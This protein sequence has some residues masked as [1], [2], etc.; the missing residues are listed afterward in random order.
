MGEKIVTLISVAL[1]SFLLLITVALVS[2]SYQTRVTMST[3]DDFVN[4]IMFNGYFSKESYYN[5]LAKIP[6]KNIKIN[7]S[8]YV[9]EEEGEWD[10][11]REAL[12]IL[13]TDGIL[14][15][16]DERYLDRNMNY[17]ENNYMQVGD[18]FKVDVIQLGTNSFETLM[19]A[20][21]G[22]GNAPFKMIVSRHTVIANTKYEYS[23]NE[24]HYDDD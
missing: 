23:R 4:E 13:F 7:M 6:M 5:M 18:V 16:H 15:G 22:Q 2:S 10:E 8:R 24:T 19:G 9:R 1:A 11:D 14:Q 3:V 20:L 21:A 12:N 17:L